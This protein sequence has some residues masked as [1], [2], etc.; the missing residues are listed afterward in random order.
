MK[1][2]FALAVL[3]SFVIFNTLLHSQGIFLEKGEAGVFIDG[4]YT[5]IENGTGS[6]IGGGFAIGGIFEFGFSISNLKMELDNYYYNYS[7]KNRS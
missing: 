3:V 7:Q 4:S 5:T 2:S 1:N 6:N